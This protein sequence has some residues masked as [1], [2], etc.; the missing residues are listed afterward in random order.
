MTVRSNCLLAGI[1][2][3]LLVFHTNAAE[4]NRKVGAPLGRPRIN[5]QDGVVPR[6]FAAGLR[7]IGAIQKHVV[8]SHWRC[9]SILELAK[10][11]AAEPNELRVLWE[12]SSCADGATQRDSQ[13]ASLITDPR[14]YLRKFHRFSKECVH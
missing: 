6:V 3:A 8:E 14:T 12:L 9:K 7:R 5:T 1:P 11:I 13:P 4:A 10:A 2:P